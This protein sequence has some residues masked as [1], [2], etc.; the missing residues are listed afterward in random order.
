MAPSVTPLT[1][2][3]M[4]APNAKGA[5]TAASASLPKS[6]LEYIADLHD[7]LSEDASATGE[8]TAVLRRIRGSSELSESASPFRER[9]NAA[10]RRL[11]PAR[12]HGPD[13]RFFR[14]LLV[15]DAHRAGAGIREVH[16][17]LGGVS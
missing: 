6:L 7:S 11:H 4:R 17:A 12:I 10:G 16:A 8:R 2:E 9:E 14:R 5:G 15:E 13:H 3:S 1:V